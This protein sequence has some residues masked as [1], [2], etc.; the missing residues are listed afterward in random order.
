MWLWSGSMFSWGLIFH[1]FH[2]ALSSTTNRAAQH[3][4][5]ANGIE[6]W[7]SPCKG[8]EVSYTRP[9]L[10]NKHAYPHRSTTRTI[11]TLCWVSAAGGQLSRS[12]SSAGRWVEPSRHMIKTTVTRHKLFEPIYPMLV[13]TEPTRSL[14]AP[15]LYVEVLFIR[16]EVRGVGYRFDIACSTNHD[17]L[18][19]FQLSSFSS[20]GLPS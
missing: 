13:Y 11:S 7:N 5:L 15:H 12:R 6:R 8:D 9:C 2:K 18:V 17:G 3:L 16:E 14:T 4:S 19:G 10:A 1:L 20:P